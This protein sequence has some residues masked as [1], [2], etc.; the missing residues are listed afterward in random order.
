[1]AEER[2]AEKRPRGQW[3]LG[4]QGG[5]DSTGRKIASKIR[6]LDG[7]G[8]MQDAPN[9]LAPPGRAPQLQGEIQI[10]AESQVLLQISFRG[11][12]P[13]G[14]VRGS[15]GLA[16]KFKEVMRLAQVDQ[17]VEERR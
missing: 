10:D 11:D 16:D 8:L 13:N 3:G 9:Q 14:P 12:E 15:H 7:R 6:H 2:D 17:L 5:R 4:D 1:M